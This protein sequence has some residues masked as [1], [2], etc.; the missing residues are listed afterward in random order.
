VAQKLLAL[1][2]N[3]ADA[4]LAI[5][6]ENYVLGQQP[7]PV[8][9]LLKLDGAMTNQNEGIAE[10]QKTA[11]DGHYL[12]PYAQILLALAAVHAHDPV[13]ARALLEPLVAEF[14]RNPLYPEALERLDIQARL[15]PK[16]THIRFTL[17]ALLHTVHGTFALASGADANLVAVDP[18]NGT[19]TGRVTV[20]AK[21]GETG[22][23][24]RD[25]DMQKSV[26]ESQTYP[27][28]VFLPA[29]LEGALAR[30][31]VSQVTLT[32]TIRLVGGEHPFALPLTVTVNGSRFTATG[33]VTVPY[34]AWGLHNPSTLFLR[35]HK[36][37][38][39][40]LATAGTITWPPAK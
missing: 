8:R 32:G 30:R 1:D 3:Y 15:D 35:V 19:A 13:R 10:L 12:Q 31:G 39:L 4:Y 17:G 22:N 16:A 29:K 18:D 20:A 11:A 21:S 36:T 2:P 6:M 34:V 26:L 9:W 37:V 38:T 14:P 27:E 24:S 33:K 25:R 28:I 5:G 23:A 40:D 7:A